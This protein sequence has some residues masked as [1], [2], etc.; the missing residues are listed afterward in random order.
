MGLDKKSWK[1]STTQMDILLIAVLVILGCFGLHGYLRGMVRMV[2]SLAA[3]FL[4]IGLACWATPYVG[5]FL[6]AQ[7]PL[8]EFIQEKC[9]EAI[10]ENIGLDLEGSIG[11][12]GGIEQVANLAAQRIAW[13]V[14][15]ILI[16]ILL[17]VLVHVLDILAKLPVIE[18]INHLGGLAVGLLE[19]VVVVWI[20][21][22]VIVL[23]QGTEWGRPMMESIQQNPL[24]R[25]LYENNVLE[26]FFY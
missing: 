1:W 22:F 23:C 4:A 16:S 6:Q 8:Q 2:F 7:T 12:G 15:F 14:S 10:Q 25:L 5:E 18:S 13:I 19:G 26:Q 21:L 17:G 3:T 11:L 24:L 20:L 9:I